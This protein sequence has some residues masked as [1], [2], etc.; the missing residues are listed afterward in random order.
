MREISTN[1][2]ERKIIDW[3]HVMIKIGQG[4]GSNFPQ[5]CAE[6][7]SNYLLPK[8]PFYMGSLIAIIWPGIKPQGYY[9][10]FTKEEEQYG[11]LCFKS[12]S[13]PQLP[14]NMDAPYQKNPRCCRNQLLPR[15]TSSIGRSVPRSAF[16]KPLDSMQST[17]PFGSQNFTAQAIMKGRNKSTGPC[18]YWSGLVS[19]SHHQEGSW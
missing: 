7:M 13:S 17:T 15:Q 9:Y 16:E 6:H 14:I 10:N 1:E 4:V 8:I 11:A 19:A 18:T 5:V 12:P 2:I 3:T